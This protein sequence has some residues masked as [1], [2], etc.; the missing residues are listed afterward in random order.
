MTTT[1]VLIWAETSSGPLFLFGNG[2]TDG[3][4]TEITTQDTAQSIGVAGQGSALLGL[5]I[6][7]SDGSVLTDVELLDASGGQ[8]LKVRGGERAAGL[9]GASNANIGGLSIPLHAGMQ[10][11][12][13]SAN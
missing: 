10:L 7:C 6:Q 1:D 5:M 4:A 3:A 8:A 9:N 2:I 13:T 11:K 12:V